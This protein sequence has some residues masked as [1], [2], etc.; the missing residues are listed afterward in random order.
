MK[1]H[2]SIFV[3]VL[4]C[5]VLAVPAIAGEGHKCTADTQTCINAYAEKMA[6]KGF[7]GV[8]LNWDEK[9]E[10]LVIKKVI[11]ETPAAKAGLKVGETLVALNGV[12]YGDKEGMKSVYKKIKAGNTVTY[13]VG[14]GKHNRDVKVTL[15]AYPQDLAA[16]YL[17]MHIMEHHLNAV[18]VN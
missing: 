3:L 2:I 13:T 14:H 12:K 16:K 17:G 1:R 8:E 6:N 15:I 4:L 11:D 10:A 5:A 18:A 9:T 7:L